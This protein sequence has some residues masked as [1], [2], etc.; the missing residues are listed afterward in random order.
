MP[1][2]P[3][4]KEGLDVEELLL[5]LLQAI[6]RLGAPGAIAMTA[7]WWLRGRELEKVRSELAASQ[8]KRIEQALTVTAVVESCRAQLALVLHALKG[9]QA[10]YEKLL[11]RLPIKGGRGGN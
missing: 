2:A 9:T 11:D 7:L 5:K 6:E 3:R 8:E 10:T 4:K 1:F